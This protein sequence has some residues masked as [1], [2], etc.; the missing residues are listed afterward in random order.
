MSTAEVLNDPTLAF[1]PES[2]FDATIAALPPHAQD[3]FD[4]FNLQYAQVAA[5]RQTHE[6]LMR[7]E[8]ERRNDI[9]RQIASI[10]GNTPADVQRRDILRGRLETANQKLA[11]LKARAVVSGKAPSIEQIEEW[12]RSAKWNRVTESNNDRTRPGARN[13]V[14]FTPPLFADAR[15]AVSPKKNQTDKAALDDAV[16][17]LAELRHERKQISRAAVSIDEA[18]TKMLA[19]IHAMAAKGAPDFSGVT[20][21]IRT[22]ATGPARQGNIRWPGESFDGG[23]WNAQDAIAFAVW[24]NLDNIIE[25]ARHDLRNQMQGRLALSAQDRADRAADLD[26]QIEHAERVVEA[27]AERCDLEGVDYV[28]NWQSSV[29]AKLGITVGEVADDERDEAIDF[30]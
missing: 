2:R 20:K 15:V 5:Q 1:D 28:R 27:W 23:P 13:L 25:R 19:D 21:R 4:L 3:R 18:E 6:T 26:K 14:G 17:T 30:G 10:K 8:T 7:A 11:S 29:P 16:A 9:E 22:T 12:I 24:A